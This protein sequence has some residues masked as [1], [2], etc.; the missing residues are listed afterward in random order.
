MHPSS[1]RPTSVPSATTAPVPGAAPRAVAAGEVS[2]G[3][4]SS[5]PAPD[6]GPL[7]PLRRSC[8]FPSPQAPAPSP[9]PPPDAA[10]AA[11]AFRARRP[12]AEAT[13]MGCSS[14]LAEAAP[15]AAD[16]RA[17]RRSVP[18][19][20]HAL[21]VLHSA[22]DM[23]RALL[24]PTQARDAAVVRQLRRNA[25]VLLDK[26]IDTPEKLQRFLSDAWRH[27]ALLGFAGLGF[28]NG[29]GYMAGITAAN[30]KLLSL[31]PADLLRDPAR[32]GL[33]AGLGIGALDMLVKAV[34]N[35]VIAPRFYN[36]VSGL[37]RLPGV[38]RPHMHAERIRNVG[39]S[40][41]FSVAKNLPRVAE[42]LVQAAIEGR[43]DHSV[44]RVWADRIDASLLDGFGGM[45]AAGARGVHTLS[46]A[47]PYDARMLLR[48]DLGDVIDRMRR[49]WRK[50]L[51]GIGPAALEGAA[52]LVTSPVPV[53]V[54]ATVG[55]FVAELFAAGATIDR[56]GTPA[57]M[58]ADRADAGMLSAKRA[59]SVL[60]MALMS[61]T[62][63]LGVPCVAGGG[64]YV[65]RTVREGLR[66]TSCDLMAW[67]RHRFGAQPLPD[68][69]AGRRS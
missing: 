66:R 21:P 19:P 8:S 55:C 16:G 24:E 5:R 37:E 52:S 36:G 22:Q 33:L 6:T 11:D 47:V 28:S 62:I 10:A 39:L 46:Q 17:Y 13:P 65:A 67:A 51:R 9:G 40:V 15:G 43:G 30:E 58:P 48:S 57:G 32:L 7:G 27:D 3:P 4:R 42:P 26:G 68:I 69:E 54:V 63:E 64:A 14:V 61:G 18:L 44:N 35:A 53:A 29:A 2:R 31:M 23:V 49:P 59:S 45:L 12:S 50:S 60:L 56:A 25:Q 34:G 20:A 1:P 38:L 41:G